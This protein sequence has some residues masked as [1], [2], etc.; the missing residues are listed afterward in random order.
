[1]FANKIHGSSMSLRNNGGVN[2]TAA[3]SY[4]FVMEAS[5]ESSISAR[6]LSTFFVVE[7]G[8][9]SSEYMVD[10]T[11]VKI[12]ASSQDKMKRRNKRDWV[13]VSKHLE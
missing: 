1:M 3:F 8:L 4:Q 7:V 12:R 5:R 13:D 6:E 2:S 9:F 11:M 10:I